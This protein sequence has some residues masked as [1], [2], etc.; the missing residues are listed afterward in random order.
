MHWPKLI[1]TPA[2]DSLLHAVR[3]ACLAAIGTVL[4]GDAHV[5]TNA[6]CTP[7]AQCVE[8]GGRGAGGFDGAA[9]VGIA[10][11]QQSSFAEGV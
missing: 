7:S 9:V 1:G 11:G 4:A 8:L 3:C 2:L 5:A 6:G 10:G